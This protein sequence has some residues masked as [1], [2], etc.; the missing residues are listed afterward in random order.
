[1]VE[2]GKVT[3]RD[4]LIAVAG[5]VS[6]GA[7]A[8]WARHAAVSLGAKHARVSDI[9]ARFMREFEIPGVG[10]AIVRADRSAFVQGYGIRTLGQPG[11]IDEHTQFAIASNSK[12]FLSASFAM[13]VD[14][15][16]LGWEDLVVK[17]LPEFRMY[18][19]A[20]TAMMTVL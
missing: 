16:K 10:I 8:A 11:Q 4:A 20:V 6:L 15:G 5:G 12:A 9:V 18:D 1:M 7:R 14:E 13:L 2:P 19:P 17:H 3:R